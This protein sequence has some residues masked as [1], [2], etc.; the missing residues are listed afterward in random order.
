MSQF[1][2]SGDK[3]IYKLTIQILKQ[4]LG[5]VGMYTGISN[6]HLKI[7]FLNPNNFKFLISALKTLKGTTQN[8]F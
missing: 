6:L 7:Q 5:Q 8:I 2:A 4:L 1:F 3:S